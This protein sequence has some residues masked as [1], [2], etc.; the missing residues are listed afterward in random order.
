MSTE[1]P[2]ITIDGPAA[3]GKG[4]VAGLVAR[5]LGFTHFNSGQMYRLVG[6]RAKQAGASLTDSIAVQKASRELLSDPDA[7]DEA[8]VNPALGDAAA[9]DAGSAIA[10]LPEVRTALLEPQRRMRKLPGLVAE[11]RDMGSIIFPD[12]T[13]KVFID[14]SYEVRKQRALQRATDL[15]NDTISNCINLF[16]VRDKRDRQ[17]DIAPIIPAAKAHVIDTDDLTVKATV[18][19]IVELYRNAAKQG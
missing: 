7:L 3:V 16:K 19:Q 13:L 17:R 6:W 8:L 4:T 15:Q 1:I 14:A 9:A 2:V 11:G 18:A 5:E 12:A 10:L